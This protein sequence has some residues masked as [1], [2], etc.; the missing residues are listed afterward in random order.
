MFSLL[1]YNDLMITVQKRNMLTVLLVLPLVLSACAPV[2]NTEVA[3]AT[4]TA[5]LVETPIVVISQEPT[6]TPEITIDK[7]EE[8]K[9]PEAD[10]ALAFG[11]YEQALETYQA[12]FEQSS[13][14]T[15]K[16]AALFGISITHF[17]MEN[18]PLVLS[19]V[20]NLHTDYPQ[21]L[22]AKRA[23]I[24]LGWTYQALGRNYDA[25]TE[26]KIYLTDMPGVIDAY[27]YEQIGD[28][29]L[30]EA[31]L[32]EALSAYQ[33]AYLS[34]LTGSGED[35]AIKI[36][37]T[38]SLLGD[39]ATAINLYKDIYFN[40]QSDYIKAQM[41]I[42]LARAYIAE[43]DTALAYESY[44]DAVNNYPFTYDAYT[45]LVELVNN[46]E[47]VNEL[48]RGIINANIEQYELAIE[49]YNR[50]LALLEAD[51]AAGLYYKALAIRALGLKNEPIGGLI[52]TEANQKEG[53]EADNQAV[54]LWREI[55]SKYPNSQFAIDAWEDIA[56]TQSAY[57]NDPMAAARTARDFV[58]NA[59][60]SP[61]SSSILFSA[62][63]YFEIAGDLQEAAATWSRLG[64]E[65]P[66]TSETF[67]ALFFAGIT[68]Y[69][70]QDFENALLSFNRAIV[71]SFEPLEISAAYMWIG[72]T[73]REQGNTDEGNDALRQARTEDPFGYYGI[74]AEEILN[75]QAPFSE[76]NNLDTEIDWDME[77]KEASEWIAS[78]FAV[79]ENSDLED[80]S[81]LTLDPAFIR[82]NE[83][84]KLGQYALSKN[85]FEALRV[86]S[87]S[88][89]VE[90]FKLTQALLD[91]GLNRQAI[92][93]A[94]S[95][96]GLAGLNYEDV[97]SYPAYFG[98]VIYGLYYLPWISDAVANKEIP[99]LYIYSLINQESHF[100]G[101]IESSAGARGL[102]QILPQTGA[103]IASEINFPAD[104]SADDLSIPYIN[105][106][107]GSN[108]LNRQVYLF[109]GDLYAAAAAYNGGP[110]S[111]LEWKEMAGDDPDL[112][113]GVVRFLE[114]R[115][116][117]RQIVEIYT[118]YAELYSQ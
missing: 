27:V 118:A 48:K 72:K 75:S 30:S 97:A 68:Y 112:F 71:L 51:T 22:P 12:Y 87:R 81:E 32:T 40:S 107:L 114:T 61:S 63:R 73:N 57:I 77:R 106:V 93:S 66:N 46:G 29:Y 14:A 35:L 86:A 60:D 99:L 85:E 42:F 90:L 33:S 13:I 38:Y 62:G 16:A 9:I 7:T 34:P 47:T 105:L 21:E 115:T 82:G 103:Q 19:N 17:K 4:K 24:L 45:A 116:Y 109:D 58:A 79:T 43:Q 64:T 11:D 15:E 44:Q 83:F 1:H 76:P 26:F 10:S 39:N 96:I 95:I 53:T 8:A 36:A 113:A 56:Y 67:Q 69:R 110:G 50:Y 92:E 101:F 55:T 111:A 80:M 6:E 31:N 98:H 5:V 88:D 41:D 49:A 91:L 117:I 104:F 52:R 102:M 70:L 94:K 78:T 108:Y 37:N 28:I 59:P 74:R 3:L 65:Y 89:A 25:L 18:F 54:A 20:R 23:H 2:S 84:W 100:E